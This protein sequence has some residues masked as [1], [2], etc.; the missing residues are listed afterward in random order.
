MSRNYLIWQYH[1]KPKALSTI[2]AIY[3]I[4]DDSFKTVLNIAD[5]LDIDTASGYALDLVGRHVGIK[6]VLSQAIAKEFFG[7]L[8]SDSSLAFDVGEFYQYGD[9]LNA[10]VRLNDDDYR[11][12]IKAKI[13]KNYQNGTSEF[14]VDSIR[15]LLGGTGNAIDN[16]DMTMHVIVNREQLNS[17]KLYAIKNLDILARPVGVLYR[18]LV[19]TNNTPFGF[20]RAHRAYGFGIGK[21]VRLQEIGKFNESTK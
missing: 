8:E 18:F 16:L 17:I 3:A 1:D 9:S 6:R 20:Y 13:L 2:K 12:F 21:F 14:I 15:Y 10:T 11:F 5:I 19:I 4:T 7:F